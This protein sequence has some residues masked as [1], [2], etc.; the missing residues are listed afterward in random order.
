M[1]ER[2]VLSQLEETIVRLPLGDQLLLIE[3]LSKHI[4]G[5]ISPSVLFGPQLEAMAADPEIQTELDA[6]A[7]E[8]SV[9]EGDGLRVS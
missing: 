3:R 5:S 9:T 7:D 4:R 2:S 8:F 1:T 6:I